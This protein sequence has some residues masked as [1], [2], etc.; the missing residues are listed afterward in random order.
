MVLRL[1]GEIGWFGDGPSHGVDRY[2]LRTARVEGRAYSVTFRSRPAACSHGI[3][4]V[5]AR[6]A[7]LQKLHGYFNQ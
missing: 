1:D 5:D 3:E 7:T 2:S 4:K 6:S